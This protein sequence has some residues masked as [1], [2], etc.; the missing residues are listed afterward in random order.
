MAPAVVGFEERRA[1]ATDAEPSLAGAIETAPR[2]HASAIERPADTGPAP[3]TAP[4]APGQ[5]EAVV[6]VAEPAVATT[7]GALQT[8][9]WTYSALLVVG[10]PLVV[11]AGGAAWAPAP[12]LLV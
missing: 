3:R 4:A 6:V 1:G 9:P 11:G 2:S 8:F 7:T 10:A 12:A 5:A